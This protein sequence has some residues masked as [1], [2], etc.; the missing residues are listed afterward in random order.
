MNQLSRISDS[1]FNA[2]ML[3]ISDSEVQVCILGCIRLEKILLW[4]GFRAAQRGTDT[5]VRVP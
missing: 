4:Q 5:Y 2:S 3:D 1:E